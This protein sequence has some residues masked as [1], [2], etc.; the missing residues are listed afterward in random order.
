MQL[1][2]QTEA[3]FAVIKYTGIRPDIVV[4]L[5][6]KQLSILV[7]LTVPYKS[8]IE[9]HVFKSARYSNLI[10]QVRHVSGVKSRVLQRSIQEYS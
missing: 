1:T 5:R 9:E 10:K 7:E 2:F 8:R 6:N 4:Y 3:I